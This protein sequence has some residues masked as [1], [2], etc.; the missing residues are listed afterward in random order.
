MEDGITWK[1]IRP[2]E[3]TNPR[4]TTVAGFFTLFKFPWQIEEVMERF[5]NLLHELVPQKGQ[6]D[7]SRN[8]ILLQWEH[9]VLICLPQ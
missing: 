1:T 7:K 5:R 9:S 2:P 4:N 6:L 8:I 3:K